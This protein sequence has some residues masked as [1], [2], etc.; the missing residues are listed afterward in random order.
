MRVKVAP[1]EAE[2]WSWYEE[3]NGN[4]FGDALDDGTCIGCHATGPGGFPS[5]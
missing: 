4:I 1:G 2:G 5:P 3:F